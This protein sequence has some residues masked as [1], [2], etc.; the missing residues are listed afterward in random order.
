MVLGLRKAVS[1]LINYLQDILVNIIKYAK[2]LED[3][4]VNIIK[5]AKLLEDMLVNVIRKIKISSRVFII[6]MNF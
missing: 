4:L 6:C 1:C 5:Y 3:M 2:L